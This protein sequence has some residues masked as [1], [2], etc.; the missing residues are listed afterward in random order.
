MAEVSAVSSILIETYESVKSY[1]PEAVQSFLNL[2]LL[3]LLIVLYCVFIW[4]FDKLIAKKNILGL[5]L[6]KYNKSSHPFLTKLFAGGLYFAEYVIIL[7][8]VI[9][10][11]FSIFT[12]FLILL[13]ES[14]TVSQILIIS[15]T[16]VA[17]IRIIAYYKEG[18]AFE[19]AKVLPFTLLSVS[20][21]NP[22]FF[23]VERILTNFGELPTFFEN[24]FYYLF[25]IVVIELILRGFDFLLSLFGLEE[26]KKLD[27]EDKK[28]DID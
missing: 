8:F 11:W 28:G 3:V 4:K 24:I 1:L 6:N 9:L 12:I 19:M 14:L 27:E 16:I 21:L 25:F 18:L 17:A 7:P 22:G 2:F 20:I 23:D 15:A 26:E 13:T 5:N 10:F